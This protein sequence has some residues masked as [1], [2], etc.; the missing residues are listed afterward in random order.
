MGELELARDSLLAARALHPSDS[1][2]H[3]ALAQVDEER[4]ALA[5]ALASARRARELAPFDPSPAFVLAALLAELGQPEEAAEQ[6]AVFAR[7]APLAVEIDDLELRLLHLPNDRSALAKL[8]R[9]HA[10]L[11]DHGGTARAVRRLGPGTVLG[12]SLTLELLAEADPAAAEVAER[13]LTTEHGSD[14]AA[15]DA[16]AAHHGR[17]GDTARRDL[18]LERAAALRAGRPGGAQGADGVR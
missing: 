13:R 11:G 1:A 2:V 6:R 17:R 15:W 18:A 8:A 10:A 14:P 16:L 9:C 7:L 4:G 5:D 3:L 12:A